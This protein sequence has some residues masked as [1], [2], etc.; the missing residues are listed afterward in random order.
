MTT[1]RLRGSS[2]ETFFRL[3]VRAPR[4]RME[5]KRSRRKSETCYY[6]ALHFR[7][8]LLPLTPDRMSAA[9]LRAGASLAAVF[10]LRML[11]LFLI[12]PVFSVH[13]PNLAGGA[14]PPPA[15][16]RGRRQSHARRHRARRVRSFA[17]DLADPLRHGF[18]PLG[19]EA[20]DLHRARHL[21]GRQ[22]PRRHG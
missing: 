6:S 2:T 14:I 3:C 10:G 18:R 5:S 19:K 12:L 21:R 22:L 11:G 13:A 1:R 15:G 20:R 8:A 9:E 7:A 17:S 16:A 4:M